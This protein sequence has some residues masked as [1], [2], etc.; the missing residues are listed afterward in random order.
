ML[1]EKEIFSAFIGATIDKQTFNKVACKNGGQYLICNADYISDPQ[2]REI[3]GVTDALEEK[4]GYSGI[5]FSLH[6]TIEGDTISK[7]HLDKYRE[8]CGG[9]GRPIIRVLTPTQQELRI[10]RRILQYITK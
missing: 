5:D 1:T 2:L 3:F 6:I 9:H 8:S 7:G 10:A 4:W